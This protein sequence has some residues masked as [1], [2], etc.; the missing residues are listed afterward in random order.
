MSKLTSPEFLELCF[1]AS[2]PPG[3]PVLEHF[4]QQVRRAYR[5]YG[6]AEVDRVFKEELELFLKEHPVR[7]ASI[8]RIY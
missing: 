4:E 5:L 1:L 7:K 2:P 6:T 8:T 3:Q